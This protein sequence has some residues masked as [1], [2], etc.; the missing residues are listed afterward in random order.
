MS[1]PSSDPSRLWLWGI[2]ACKTALQNPHRKCFRLLITDSTLKELP[3]ALKE[4]PCKYEVVEGGG[5]T[6]LLA[7]GAVHQGIALEVAPLEESSFLELNQQESGVLVVLDQVTD[8]HNVGA[9]LRTAKALGAL[10]VIMT[11]RNAPPLSGV[12]AKAA[13]GA[14]DL[15]P[16][17]K[18]TNLART[19][20]E[21]KKFGFW[22]MG[23]DE[24]GTQVLSKKDAP[25]KV[26]LILGAEGEGMRRLTQ[27]R[28]DFLVKLP[29]NPEFST[30]NV[31]VAMALALY[32]LVRN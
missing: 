27:E 31:S 4:L 1:R 2:H 32:E 24:G 12:L 20:D 11:D 15:L 8:P 26:A 3:I 29:T 21:L 13:S 18:V 6:R 9:I 7:P 14:L 19:L 17:W 28:C 10:G 23:L 16:V 30:L 5:L 22:T 25:S